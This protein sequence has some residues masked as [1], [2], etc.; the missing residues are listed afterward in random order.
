MKK[1]FL[2]IALSLGGISAAAATLS[3]SEVQARDSEVAVRLSRMIMSE[4]TYKLTLRQMLQGMTQGSQAA[5]KPL[6]QD[7][8]Q[9]LALVLEEAMPLK[10]LQQRS[11][12][13]YATHFSDKELKDV[14]AFYETPTGA[15]MMKKTPELMQ[16]IGVYMAQILPQR[17]PPLMKKH[18]LAP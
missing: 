5:G 7:Y 2:A 3:S 10:E 16:D 12:Q 11:A 6:P 9:K 13:V 18:G 14:I 4:E 8:P 17:L 1:L 15:K